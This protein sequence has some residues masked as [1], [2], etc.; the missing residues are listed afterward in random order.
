VPQFI[1]KYIDKKRYEYSI[2]QTQ[3]AG[4]ASELAAN[5]VR[6]GYDVVVAV[7]GDGT[8]NEVASVLSHT[9]V[10]LGVI[11]CGSGNGFARHLG[12]PITVKG[13]I[14][15]INVAEPVRI[16]YGRL[17]GRPFFCSCG[18]GFDALV[19]N[20]FANSGNRGLFTY[21]QKTL[22]DW[23]TYKPEVYE[24]E[25]EDGM[26]KY[27]AFVIACGNASQYGNNAYITPFASMCDGMLNVSVLSP[28][29]ALEVPLIVTQLFN[30]TLASNSH[31]T[32]FNTRWVKIKRKSAGPVHYDGEPCVM[33]AELLIDV[34]PEGLCVLAAPGWNGTCAPV[35][36]Y[37]QFYDV[38]AGAV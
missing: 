38:V 2:E 23:V 21:I 33:D 12:V 27:K 29:T 7:G 34:V 20:D 17:N 25:T 35:P 14:E 19:S 31:M 16:D 6:D 26:K 32:T 4:H 5:A 36:I 11:P 9:S 30:N 10:A 8:I 28:F 15:F 37:K 13:A 22:I 1:K 24:V 18:V 3:Y